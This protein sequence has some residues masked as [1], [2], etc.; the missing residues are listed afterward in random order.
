MKPL[1]LHDLRKPRPRLPFNE[2]V[3]L[4][5]VQELQ[6]QPAP[7]HVR[8]AREWLTEIRK[9][10]PRRDVSLEEYPPL[11]DPEEMEVVN[12]IVRTYLLN[13]EVPSD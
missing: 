6:P 13:Y 10:T 1:T 7:D 8:K 2:D 9:Y 5:I 12:R 3:F 11:P 4:R